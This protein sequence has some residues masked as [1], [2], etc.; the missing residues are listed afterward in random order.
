MCL[1]AHIASRSALTGVPWDDAA[2]SLLVKPLADPYRPVTAVFSNPQVS[3]VGSYEEGCACYFRHVWRGDDND[4]PELE[5]TPDEFGH[6]E[7]E[8]MHVTASTA[9]LVALLH[10][11]AIRDGGAEVYAFW[12]GDQDLPPIDTVRLHLAELKP[13]TFLVVE[14]RLLVIEGQGA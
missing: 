10:A 8:P 1:I 9:A 12:D 4:S 3:S 11:V 13:E 2:P 14:R 7:P 6:L 5:L